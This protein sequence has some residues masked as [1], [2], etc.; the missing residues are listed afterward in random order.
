[1]QLL[2]QGPAYIFYFLGHFLFSLQSNC[3]L[4]LLS[5]KDCWQVRLHQCFLQAVIVWLESVTRL[6]SSHDFWWLGLDLS[7]VE[8]N[9]DSTRVTFFTEWLDSTRVRVIFTKPLSYW[10]TNSLL[11]HT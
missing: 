4:L 6:D 3:V 11:L 2:Q 7:H 5:C 1:M 9:S 8:K 10:S